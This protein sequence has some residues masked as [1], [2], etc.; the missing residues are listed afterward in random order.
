MNLSG[1]VNRP[2]SFP[3]GG[4]FGQGE[5]PAWLNTKFVHLEY[6]R[7]ITFDFVSSKNTADSKY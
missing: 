5:E 1:V 7:S 4:L 6:A 3:V 2:F